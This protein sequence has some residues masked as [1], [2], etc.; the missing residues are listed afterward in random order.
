MVSDFAI[1]EAL[2]HA[3]ELLI[4]LQEREERCLRDR[5]RIRKELSEIE[6]GI[7]LA[8]KVGAALDAL[9]SELFQSLTSSLE[10]NLTVALQEVLEQSLEFKAKPT[11]RRNQIEIDFSI[12]RSGQ[13]EDIMKGQGGS[14]ANVLSVGL[15]IFAL[16]TLDPKLHRRFLLLDEPDC[17]LRPDLV[18]R[19]VKIIHDAG[20]ALGF[21][22]ILISHHAETSFKKYADRIYTFSPDTGEGVR[23]ETEDLTRYP[24]GEADDAPNPK[25]PDIPP[26]A[27]N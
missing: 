15:R 4:R 1:P 9:Q 5:D 21:Q 20:E 25:S 22:V 7:R 10:K 11:L 2:G 27:A 13:E 18:P 8:P 19:L 24:D 23:V 16:I 26:T 6:Y 17:W 14:V 3:K 12:E